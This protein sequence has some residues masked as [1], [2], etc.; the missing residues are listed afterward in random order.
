MLAVTTFCHEAYFTY[1]SLR[2]AAR[3]L[4]PCEEASLPALRAGSKVFCDIVVE[5]TLPV[6]RARET[7]IE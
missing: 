1:E 5:K 4:A 2:A 6:L 7:S 3:E